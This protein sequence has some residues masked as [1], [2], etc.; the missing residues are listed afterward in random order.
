MTFKILNPSTT[1]GFLNFN[2]IFEAF[3]RSP[4]GV[5]EP[6]CYI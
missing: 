1:I 6:Q 4:E 5:L 2:S 3:I